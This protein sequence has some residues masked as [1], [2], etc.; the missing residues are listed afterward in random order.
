MD[1]DRRQHLSVFC[2]ALECVTSWH[3]HIQTDRAATERH[4]NEKRI[5]VVV[6]EEGE[7]FLDVVDSSFLFS[8]VKYVSLFLLFFLFRRRWLF[9]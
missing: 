5:V 4:A 8:D 1:G 6:V 7:C 3:I 9:F 2:D